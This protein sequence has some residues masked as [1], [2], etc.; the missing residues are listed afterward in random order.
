MAG[1]GPAPDPNSRNQRSKSKSG[2]TTLP[3]EG[4]AGPVP[5][6]P[7]HTDPSDAELI[8]WGSLWVKPQA[9]MWEKEG[10]ERVV[11]RYVMVTIL[12]E[13]PS[14]PSAALLGEVRQMED[15]LGLSPMAM[16]RLMW[17]VGPGEVKS[18]HLAEVKQFDRFKDL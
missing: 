5:D 17:V 6:W 12:A 8:M 9:V 15:R 16:K 2:V 14:S 1:M 10:A 11:A 18:N 7:L 4:R 3:P 13:D